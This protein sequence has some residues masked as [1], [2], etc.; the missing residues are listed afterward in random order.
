MFI[1]GDPETIYGV[2]VLAEPCIHS[3][4]KPISQVKKEVVAEDSNRGQFDK[5][6]IKHLIK[7]N[8]KVEK[9]IETKRK[10]DKSEFKK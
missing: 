6:T 8:K 5:N 4:I 2:Y 10:R 7:A 1:K 3:V 9:P